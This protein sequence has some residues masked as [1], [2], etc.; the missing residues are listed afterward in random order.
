MSINNDNGFNVD[1]QLK[2]MSESDRS[3]FINPV[4]SNCLL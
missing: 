3:W 4:V 1:S 2:K